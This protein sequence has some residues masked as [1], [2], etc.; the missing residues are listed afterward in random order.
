[1]S[2]YLEQTA[3]YR[4]SATNAQGA[5]PPTRA[6]RGFNLRLWGLHYN[7]QAVEA[8]RQGQLVK[9]A[10]GNVGQRKLVSRPVF[11]LAWVPELP[12]YKQRF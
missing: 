1:M 10:Q 8:C 12:D 9:T 11:C 4:L 5:L 2:T 3:M 6:D 7:K